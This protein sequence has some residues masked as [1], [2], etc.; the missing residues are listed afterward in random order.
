MVRR[1]NSVGIPK[2]ASYGYFYFMPFATGPW[3]TP[4]DL[5]DE[6]ATLCLVLL[7]HAAYG[8]SHHT[9][10]Y[11]RHQWWF[12]DGA[13]LSNERRVLKWAWIT[14]SIERMAEV[15][16]PAEP[17]AES[18]LFAPFHVTDHEN[19][20][21]LTAYITELKQENIRLRAHLVTVIG[22]SE[23]KDTPETIALVQK[24]ERELEKLR[25]Q[26]QGQMKVQQ[27]SDKQWR[28]RMN[29]LTKEVTSLRAKLNFARPGMWRR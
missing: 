4:P 7:E 1:E 17:P 14:D 2:A 10:R 11:A 12:E 13:Q 8:R 16:A 15:P 23:P 5:P 25:G 20:L 9:M 18:R 22:R 19:L 21:L 6:G 3:H 27:D 29:Q 24:L 26:L 28:D